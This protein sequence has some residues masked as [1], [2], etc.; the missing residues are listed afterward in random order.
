MEET[1]TPWSV[2]VIYMLILLFMMVAGTVKGQ[3]ICKTDVC[4]VEFNAG[5]NKA[6]SVDWLDKLNDCG[7][8]RI[9]ID[10]GDWQKKYNIV[11]VPTIIIFNGEEVERFQADLSFEITA[12]LEDIQNIIDEILMEDF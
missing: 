3:N 9:N 6:N 5:W 10:E 1:K 11:V 2:Y 12:K 8:Q 4:V 7:V